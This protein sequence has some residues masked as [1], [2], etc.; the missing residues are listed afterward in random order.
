MG[1]VNLI[2]I[3]YIFIDFIFDLCDNN[4]KNVQRKHL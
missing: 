4:S 3:S 1:N 2:I